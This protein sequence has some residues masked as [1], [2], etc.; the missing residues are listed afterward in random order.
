ML[1]ANAPSPTVSNLLPPFW[2]ASFSMNLMSMPARRG[3]GAEH[4]TRSDVFLLACR[5]PAFGLPWQ[6]AAALVS[7]EPRLKPRLEPRLELATARGQQLTTHYSLVTDGRAAQQLIHARVVN[8]LVGDMPGSVRL[9][10]GYAGRT[11]SELVGDVEPRL[12]ASDDVGGGALGAAA[13]RP[14]GW[15]LPPSMVSSHPEPPRAAQSRP[16]R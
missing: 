9:H 10:T 15:F 13:G 16:G 11:A 8:E 3:G 6:T 12:L 5:T 4:G 1:E 14:M 7:P 2:A